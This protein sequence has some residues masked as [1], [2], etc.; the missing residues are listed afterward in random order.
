MKVRLSRVAD[1]VFLQ[2]ED[3]PEDGGHR[4]AVFLDDGYADTLADIMKPIDTHSVDTVDITLSVNGMVSMDGITMP[5]V[6]DNKR[7]S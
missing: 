2:F 7:V 3:E 1:G 4:A 6:V 5:E